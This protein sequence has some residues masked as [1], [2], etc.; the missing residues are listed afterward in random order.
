MGKSLRGHGQRLSRCSNSLNK[1]IA[2]CVFGKN[3]ALVAH[4]QCSGTTSAWPSCSALGEDGT[5]T[6]R[7]GDGFAAH[8]SAALPPCRSAIRPSPTAL[9]EQTPGCSGVLNNSVPGFASVWNP[10]KTVTWRPGLRRFWRRMPVLW[11]VWD[12][13]CPGYARCLWEL[14]ICWLARSARCSPFV[15]N[16][17]SGWSGGPM[18]G[19]IARHMF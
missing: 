18:R 8:G 12:D 16:K 13:L 19:T 4:P 1:A 17:G 10:G 3:P 15:G 7:C 5:R 9:S 14:G 2:I 11:I 6:W